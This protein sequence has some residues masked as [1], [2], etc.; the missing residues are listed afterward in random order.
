MNSLERV[1][2]ISSILNEKKAQDIIAIEIKGIS[3]LSDY[4]VIASASST[5]QVSALANEIDDRFA[6]LGIEPRQREGLNSAS[7]ILMDYGDVIVHIFYKETRDFYALERLW[8]D[9][10]RLDLSDIL[11]E[12]N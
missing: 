9:A 12:N 2:M 5:T 8:S 11:T 4:F 1:R 10:P 6:K 7:W 3:I